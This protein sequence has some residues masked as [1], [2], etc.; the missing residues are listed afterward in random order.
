MDKKDIRKQILMTLRNS[1]GPDPALVAEKLCSLEEYRQAET[2]LAY[3]P[4]K[5]EV[6]ISLFIDRALEDGK[7]V[8][9]PDSE[10]G[11]FRIADQKW[12]T[13]LTTLENRT[14]TTEGCPVLNINSCNGIVSSTKGIILVPGLAFTEFGTRLGRGAGYYDQLLTLMAQSGFADFT[15]IGICRKSQLVEE[16]PQQPHDIKVDM[17]LAF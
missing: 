14:Q 16:L 1:P 8:A 13:R 17:V 4:L 15:S 7:T 12:R 5:S 9:F 10:I 3:V 2:V 6:D 11:I